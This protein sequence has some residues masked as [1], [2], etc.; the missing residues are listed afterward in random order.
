[1]LKPVSILALLLSAA[2]AVQAAQEVNVYS[3]R[4]EALIKPV[5]DDFTKQTGIQ[6]NLITGNADTLLSR[7][8][9]EGQFSPADLLVTTDVGR[10]Q[11]A[12]ESGL[13]QG[14]QANEQLAQWVPENLR[15][16]DNQWFALT[17]RARPIMYAIDRVKPEELNR[18]EDLTDAKW[19]GRVCVRS[20]TNIYNQSMVSALIEQ[21][22]EPATLEWAKGLVKNFARP[23]KGGDR[24]Q[25]KAVAAGQCDIAIANTYYL[26]GMLKDADQSQ[27]E[28]AKKVKVFWPNQADRGA[29]VNISG[30]AVTKHAPNA[31]NANKLLVFMLGKDAQ[32][33]YAEHN[34]EYPVRS[35]VNI[36]EVLKGFGEFKAESIPLEKVGA[37]NTDA[38]MLMNHA[39]WK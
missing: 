11:W 12:K 2:T 5:L 16:Q 32:Q 20:S 22:G 37:R 18:L 36:S 7:I 14:A 17:K 26:A 21:I 1:M 27:V 33:W 9:T 6:V 15:D 13:L 34:G 25:I 30:A 8:A 19:R 28:A 38:L 4:K 23:P 29:H 3:A 31:D 39:G 10:L 24:D 35:D